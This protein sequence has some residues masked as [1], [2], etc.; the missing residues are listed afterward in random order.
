MTPSLA[1]ELLEHNSD[2]RY[3]RKAHVAYLMDLIREGKYIDCHPSPVIIDLNSGNL[4][5]GQHRVQAI[6]KSGTSGIGMNVFFTDDKTVAFHVDNGIVRSLH[7]RIRKS[8]PDSIE[9]FHVSVASFFWYLH[10]HSR[11]VAPEHIIETMEEHKSSFTTM[12]HFIKSKER[13]VR[14]A[15]VWAAWVIMNILDEERSIEFAE[16]FLSPIGDIKQARLLRDYLLRK[17]MLHTS[18]IT[19][20]MDDYQRSLYCMMAY[21]KCQEISKVMRFPDLM[22][23]LI[24]KGDSSVDT[25]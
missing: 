7:D 10:G 17:C 9:P 6:A 12:S 18:G 21:I 1:M 16:S 24:I 20:R 19:T 13:G 15:S 25:P 5:D 4:L 2:N 23:H 14:K 22:L 3:I 11:K 8:V